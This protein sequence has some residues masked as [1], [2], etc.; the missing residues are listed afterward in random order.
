MKISL[1]WVSEYVQLP[2]AIETARIAHDLT[3][4]TVEVEAIEEHASGDKVLEI[5]N[6]SL[7]NR[8]DLWGHYG[9]ARELAAIY[10]TELLELPATADGM[11]ASSELVSEVDAAICNRF[12]ALH[13]SAPAGVTAPD[14][15]CSRLERIGQRSVNLWTDLSNYVMFA[16][17]QP[18]HAY[19]ARRLDFPMAVERIVH[20]VVIELLN[21]DCRALEPGSAVVSSATEPVAI[22]G[23]M[24]GKNTAVDVVTDE[25]VL[26]VA[27]FDPNTVRRMSQELNLR[28]E[29]SARFEK[30]IDTQRIDLARRVFLDLLGRVAP[31][32]AILGSQDVRKALTMPQEI[33]LRLDFLERRIGRPVAAVDVAHK[34][35]MLGFRVEHRDGALL[36]TVPTWRSTGD[37]A[38]PHDLVEEVARLAG[39]ENFAPTAP[40]VA[41]TVPR[42]R[43]RV[44]LERRLR[45][46]LA[47]RGGLQEVVTYP[48]A[49]DRLV[50]AFG[51]PKEQTI[52]FEGA[53][54]PD[55][56]SLRPSLLPN[57]VETVAGNLRHAAMFSVF[58][59]GTVF[60]REMHRG[61]DGPSA[62]L[63]EACHVAAAFVGSD[64]Q[65]LFRQA[66][67]LLEALPRVCQFRPF[68]L[69]PGP[70]D[71]WAEPDV[72]LAVV[73]DGE[74]VGVLGLLANDVA[75]LGEVSNA[76]VA[77][78]EL[79]VDRLDLFASRENRYSRLSDFP[80]VKFDLS[81][82]VNAG[83]PW[84]QIA[85]I[86]FK[87]NPLIRDVSFVDEFRGGA[88]AG[89]D[90][91]SMTF[92]VTLQGYDRT[93]AAPEIAEV[94]HLLV[95]SLG[96]KLGA[97]LRA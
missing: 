31:T 70:G 29:S 62:R 44:V 67:G 49:A 4:T 80:A 47:T 51:I 52:R 53:P 89:D 48:W 97:V 41:L 40:Q 24:G 66:K 93:L 45:E 13:V 55:R 96:D 87:E 10:E 69:S 34:L 36:V 84:A 22:A 63:G 92:R 33:E 42:R 26:E 73:V 43:P 94:R 85:E 37:V 6:K 65:A 86:V 30:G 77:C 23:V 83:V 54:S 16:V 78:F 61:V 38:L 88:I 20:P 8:P 57:L 50:E 72:Q 90:K 5:D 60:H 79:D 64:G 82:V 75:R 21:G 59:V 68:E 19:N 12:T 56:A 9:I 3:M 28:T 71:A 46:Q 11:P 35:T 15:V 7:T 39:Y 1:E 74:R 27:N 17:G 18:T 81:V 95:A 32:A 91:K 58:E 2:A 25:I 14:W 76:G